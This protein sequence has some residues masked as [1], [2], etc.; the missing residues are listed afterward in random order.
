MCYSFSNKKV[1]LDKVSAEMNAENYEKEYI[2]SENVSAFTRPALPIVLEHNGRKITHGTWGLYAEIP[3]DKPAKGLNLTA[4][5]SHTFYKNNEHS[6]CLIPI[7]GFYDFQHITNPGKKT[8]IKVK[9]EVLWKD[10][11]QFYLAGFY[12]VWENEEIGVGIV[13]TV[14]NELMSIIH[15]SKMRMPICLDARMADKFLND[16]PI[17]EF[18]YPAFDPNLIAVNLEPHKTPLTLF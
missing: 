12:D 1:D 10:A 4:E 3:K 17:E 18:V 16:A 9:H 5:K 2:L 7:N 14:A 13:T 15:N 8:P 11:D 6:R